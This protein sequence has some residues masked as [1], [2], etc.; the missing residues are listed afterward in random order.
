MLKLTESLRNAV[1]V[2][3]SLK[4]LLD[5]GTI[6]IFAAPNAPARAEDAELGT[7]L[8]IVSLN[9]DGSGLI[10]DPVAAGGVMSKP[11]GAVWKGTN[12]A[13]GVPKYYR[14]VMSGDAGDAST[15]AHRVQGSVGVAGEDMN[16][17]N[18]NFILGAETPTVFFTLTLPTF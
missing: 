6:K 7:L 15:S 12:L 18:P 9:G 11:V 4:S 13:A 16:V 14:W 2:T 8:R 5:G 17:S 10:F 3:G 1:M